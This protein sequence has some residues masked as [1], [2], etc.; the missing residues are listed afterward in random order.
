MYT[1]SVSL[2]PA[3]PSAISPLAQHCR[4][5]SVKSSGGVRSSRS[6]GVPETKSGVPEPDMPTASA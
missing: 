2:A 6:L 1:M 5:S 3:L 4:A